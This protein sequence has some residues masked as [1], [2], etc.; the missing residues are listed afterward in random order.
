MKRTEAL[1]WT[2]VMRGQPY[3]FVDLLEEVNGVFKI[4]Y[5]SIRVP[6]FLTKNWAEHEL[7]RFLIEEADLRTRLVKIL[8]LP[9]RGQTERIKKLDVTGLP[10]A[11]IIAALKIIASGQLKPEAIKIDSTW[12]SQVELILP[13]GIQL[14]LNP[15]G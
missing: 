13:D 11:P 4:R 7:L 14:I 9:L 10:A 15:V 5:P 1:G 12:K 6:K 3:D 8:G 2:R